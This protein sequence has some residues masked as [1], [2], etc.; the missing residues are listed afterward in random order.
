MK[1]LVGLVMVSLLVGAANAGT[2]VLIDATTNDGSFE[3][4]SNTATGYN[5]LN[6]GGANDLP[7]A[8]TWDISG[9]VG[10]SGG[11]MQS[12]NSFYWSD[13]TGSVN[14]DP[15]YG[16]GMLSDLNTSPTYYYKQNST[17]LVGT[18]G[19]GTT[20]LAQ[21][22]D[23][24]EWAFDLNHKGTGTSNSYLEVRM[25]FD[26]ADHAHSAL[27]LYDADFNGG[28]AA[29]W[30]TKTGSYTLTANDAADINANAFRFGLKLDGNATAIYAD[31][32]TLSVSTVPEPATLILLGLGS[33]ISLKRRK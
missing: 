29:T 20:I 10:A 7:D 33:L 15:A 17:S 12:A 4:Y 23:V 28:S 19:Y 13:R 6:A 31:N 14:P 22:G 9:V 26:G 16:V 24:L 32:F 8:G 11:L 30:V 27:Q 3:S 25:H 21:E 18:G 2:V 1:K 5:K